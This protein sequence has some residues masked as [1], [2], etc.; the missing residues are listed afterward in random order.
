M[1][2]SYHYIGLL[3]NKKT[4]GNYKTGSIISPRRRWHK[5]T[6]VILFF[7]FWYWLE[8]S[9][10]IMIKLFRNSK[11]VTCCC[12][13]C[14]CFAWAGASTTPTPS[15]GSSPT[16]PSS[17][18][19]SSRKQVK[20]FTAHHN[21]PINHIKITLLMSQIVCVKCMSKKSVSM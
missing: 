17:T 3:Y 2:I 9:K 4:A 10:I 7:L 14:W 15:P 21:I 20:L 11:C 16:T 5:C 12:S 18:K 1:L 19:R 6:N 13:F 8:S